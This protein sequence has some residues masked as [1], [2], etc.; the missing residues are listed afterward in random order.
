MATD[1][2]G[3]YNGALQLCGERKLANLTEN[4]EPRY[5]L[6]DVWSQGGVRYCLE[7][8]QW[9]FAM[10][11]SKLDY[12]DDFDPPFGFRRPFQKADDWV[13]TCAVCSDEYYRTPLLRYTDE[14]GFIYA[15]LDTIYVRYVSNSSQ[16]GMNFASWP[17]SF[18]E[19]VKAYFASKI[20][21]NLTSDE[22]KIDAVCNP[23]K[24][25][26]VIRRRTAKNK[27]AQFEG[28]QFAAQGTWT[29]SRMGGRMGRKGPMGDGGSSGSLIG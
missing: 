10:R 8:G 11:S 14:A 2:L 27:D 17:E 7:Q 16:Y 9:N 19:Y 24:G 25:E 28:T 13:M 6:D 1:Q 26:L 15:D 23:K 4:R 29:R 22:T 18:A 21:R 3:I 5:L 20:I 12:S